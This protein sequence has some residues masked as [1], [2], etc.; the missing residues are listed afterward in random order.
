MNKITICSGRGGTAHYYLSEIYRHGKQS[1]A[2]SFLCVENKEKGTDYFCDPR[3]WEGC[4]WGRWRA[5]AR[6]WMLC[7]CM[8]ISHRATPLP[9][10]NVAQISLE[11]PCQHG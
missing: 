9:A 5:A 6:E 2:S 11:A 8:G 7:A 4:G 10:I 1:T 3:D